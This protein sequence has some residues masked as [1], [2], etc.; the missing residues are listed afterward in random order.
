[1]LIPLV[2]VLLAIGSL[3]YVVDPFGM[4]QRFDLGLHRDRVARILNYRLYKTIEFRRRPRPVIVLGDSRCDLLRPE[5]FERAGFDGVYN[6]SFG[7]GT[8]PEAIDAFWFATAQTPL[9]SV[10][11][12]VPFSIYNGRERDDRVPEA[13][14][15]TNHATSYYLSPFV[16]KASFALLYER[17]TGRMLQSERPDMPREAFWQHQLGPDVAGQLASW[18]RP[19]QFD[20]QLAEI[21]GYCHEHGIT[22]T[23]LIPPNHVDLQA[24]VDEYG[25]RP[26]YERMKRHLAQLAPVIDFDRP[27]E[28]TR[29]A[30]NYNDPFHLTPE[31]AEVLVRELVQRD[32]LGGS[33]R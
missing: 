17:V 2:A 23:F 6:M 12:C 10:I 20:R 30:S 16:L 15:L 26:E 33:R 8:L 25:L 31:A 19:E 11:F 7:G 5:Y 3:N 29:R 9:R 18:R 21:A 32:G 27:S 13:L 22:L 14:A 28:L 24:K 4:N 1:M